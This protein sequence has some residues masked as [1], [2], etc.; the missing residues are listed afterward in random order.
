MYITHK[1]EGILLNDV[2]GT[3]MDGGIKSTMKKFLRRTT[4]YSSHTVPRGELIV[5]FKE[6]GQPFTYRSLHDPHIYMVCEKRK[7]SPLNT[8]QLHLLE[9]IKKPADRINAFRNKLSWGVGLTS[10]SN[11]LV[12]IPGKQYMEAE[13][14]VRYC[15]EVGQQQSHHSFGVEILVLDLYFSYMTT[16]TP[17]NS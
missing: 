1:R 12:T 4:P 10:G 5:E 2:D 6:E 3:K 7:V 9:A 16:Y 15:G 8:E 17:L 14:I 11:V 13:A